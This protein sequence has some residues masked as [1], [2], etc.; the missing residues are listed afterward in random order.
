MSDLVTLAPQVKDAGLERGFKHLSAAYN[1]RDAKGG[2]R[3]LD[4]VDANCA[5]AGLD[6]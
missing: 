3:A 6:H 4:D 5:A 2:I 1:S